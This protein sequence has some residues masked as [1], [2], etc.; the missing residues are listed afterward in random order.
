MV[1]ALLINIKA[2]NEDFPS[3]NFN[4]TLTLRFPPPLSFSRKMLNAILNDNYKCYFDIN[5]YRTMIIGYPL[6]NKK[7]AYNAKI[8]FY[9]KCNLIG[10]HF[11]IKYRGTIN[12]NDPYAI[13]ILKDVQSHIYS[14]QICDNS[15]NVIKYSDYT[16]DVNNT[17]NRNLAPPLR[18]NPPNTQLNGIRSLYCC[19]SNTASR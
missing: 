11:I 8:Y 3:A 13:G 16:C 6:L 18:D 9:W 14:Y 17:T 1:K 15:D 2:I 4:K 7:N 10:K 5:Y 19:V 12:V